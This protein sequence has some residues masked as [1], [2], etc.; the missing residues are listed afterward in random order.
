MYRQL[1]VI[2]LLTSLLGASQAFM[3]D[4]SNMTLL[5]LA[6]QIEQLTARIEYLEHKGNHFI[7]LD[8]FTS[9]SIRS[10]YINY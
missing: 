5:G 6:S 2:V 1:Y 3:L 10:L 8:K 7:P 4:S 9:T